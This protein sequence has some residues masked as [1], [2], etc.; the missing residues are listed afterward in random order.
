MVGEV[1]RRA[2]QWADADTAQ[3]R[4]GLIGGLWQAE[5]EKREALLEQ[6]TKY[7]SRV[8]KLTEALSIDRGEE[9]RTGISTPCSVRQCSLVI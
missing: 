1:H 9:V 3:E 8:V 4:C 6:M 5:T 2:L 7:V